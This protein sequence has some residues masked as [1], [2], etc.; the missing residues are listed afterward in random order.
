MTKRRDRVVRLC[1][2]RFTAS[3]FALVVLA[4]CGGG[5]GGGGQPP[6]TPEPPIVP[7]DL[8]GIW[9][10]AWQGNDPSPGG[11]GL[12]S[13][14]WEAEIHQ[15]TSSASGPAVILG[16]VDCMDGQMQTDPPGATQVN[17][18][19]G[20]APCAAVSWTLTALNVTAGT[21]A[22]SW[23]NTGTGGGG[24]LSGER[25]AP[26]G[27]PRIFFANPP[28]GKPGTV[29]TLSGQLFSGLASVRFNGVNAEP[30]Q[31]AAASRI[32]ARVPSAATTGRVQV[33]TSAGTALSPIYFSTDVMSPPASPGVSVTVG[34]MPASV[35]VSPDGRKVY[36]VDRAAPPNGRVTILRASDVSRG[37]V[38]FT[39][40]NASSPRSVV[41]SPDGKRI[42]VASAGEGVLVMD[43]ALARR[44][45]TITV[46]IN[47]EGR[48]NPQGLAISPDG[49]TLLVSSGTAGGSVSVV[50]VADKAVLATFPMASMAIAPMGV[51]FSADGERAYVAAANITGPVIP[52]GSLI[53]FDPASGAAVGGKAVG[54]LPTG[55]AVSPDGSRVF[56][57][58]QADASVSLYDEGTD[59]VKTQVVGASPTGL[60]HSP[61]GAHVLVAYRDAG[62]VGILD[63]TTGVQVAAVSVG[64]TP[65][66]I[67]I[68]P[69]GST[70]YVAN[71][72]SQN[73][74]E[75]GGMR[76]LT[77]ALTGSGIGRVS[78]SPAGIECGTSCQAQFLVN[79]PVTLAAFS[80]G[81]S[82]FSGWSA[83]CPGG[84]V[85]MTDSKNCY[86]TFIANSAPAPVGG[87]GC[88]IAT[89]AFGSSLAS[90]LQTLR[91]FRERRLM[92]NAPGRAFV[93]LYYRYSPPLADMIR[94][95][96][97]ARAVVRGV[98]RPV[99]WSI[100]HPGN[101]FAIFVLVIFVAGALRVRHA[102]AVKNAPPSPRREPDQPVTPK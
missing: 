49:T 37:A 62:S 41:A 84:I 86:A 76:T 69:K 63:S 17:G 102:H 24:T 66:G 95:H 26:L 42:Y 100:A 55:I 19:V 29:V 85:T 40:V 3:V 10:G 16:D 48:D 45:D 4:A 70:A 20:R 39:S 47:D 31:I 21:A 43:A 79:T 77:V 25:I 11:L 64:A 6:P 28:A 23:S 57:S 59:T 78:S 92:T 8:S 58:N 53:I 9:A 98:L 94:D 51:A 56:V 74:S 50:R 5:G 81:G 15:G 46:A 67:A 87:G 54:A 27:G 80:D 82:S 101:A 73:V 71:A 83:D 44:L 14:T 60:A 91:E 22:G 2:L 72:G 7:P 93:R 12:V 88:F 96:D 33:A 38:T 68:N 35:A 1:S 18:T 97:G 99:V 61:D 52:P 75:I 65:V 34:T 30:P 32:V 13:G 36:V 89:A 90:E